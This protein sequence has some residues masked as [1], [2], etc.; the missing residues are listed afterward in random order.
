M[1]KSY[2]VKFEIIATKDSK[3]FY[4]TYC[5]SC[6]GGKRNAFKIATDIILDYI[7]DMGY[8]I[9]SVYKIKEIKA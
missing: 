4:R 6:P 3:P 9:G 8:Y 5:F 2:H 1:Y 7:I